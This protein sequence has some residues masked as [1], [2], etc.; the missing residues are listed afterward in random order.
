MSKKID[1][2][3]KKYSRLTVV[4]NGLGLK[5]VCRCECGVVKEIDRYSVRSGHTTSCGCYHKEKVTKHGLS[6]SVSEKSFY[7]TGKKLGFESKQDF[8]CFLSS[9]DKKYLSPKAGAITLTR[10]QQQRYNSG[11]KES[12]SKYKGVYWNKEKKKWEARL[13][14]NGKT[15]RLGRFPTEEEAAKSYDKKAKELFGSMTYQN[16]SK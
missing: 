14:S 15:Y 4:D 10:E 2:I 11:K 16:L 7:N 13:Y 6:H 9:S 5:C 12:T 1:M 3:G 8:H